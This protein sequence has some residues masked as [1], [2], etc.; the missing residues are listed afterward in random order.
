MPMTISEQIS[1]YLKQF[2]VGIAGCGGLGS[3]CAIALA[4]CGVGKLVIADFDIVTKQNLNRQ[5]Y[6]QDQIGRLKVHALRENIQRIDASVNV[7]AFDMK[8]CVSD[9]VELFAGCHV[10]VEAFDK[11]EMKQMIIETVL[12]QMPGKYLVT[13]VGMAGWG[14]TDIIHA[15]RS[16]Q[17][18][19]CGDEVSEVSEQLPVL[20]PRVNVV[21]N[22]Q[23]NE[24]LDILLADFKPAA[25]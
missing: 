15:R 17:L 24:V 2:T 9:I 4:R 23:A 18:I 5:Y 6:F 10:I 19:I 25:F 7:K 3:N 1:N 21:A 13:G 8:L 14:K 11:A 22:M 20:A 16:D 12:M